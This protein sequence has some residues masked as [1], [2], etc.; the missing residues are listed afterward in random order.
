MTKYCSFPGCGE[1]TEKTR[2]DKHRNRDARRR[3]RAYRAIRRER[4]DGE[5]CKDCGAANVEF[6][7]DRPGRGHAPSNTS[8]RCQK[9]HGKRTA[10][11]AAVN[12]RIMRLE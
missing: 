10:A 12:A 3:G 4:I 11:Q 9:C 8:P 6:D 7:H 2:C 5:P 1:L